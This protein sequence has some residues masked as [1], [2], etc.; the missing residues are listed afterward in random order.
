M[1][2]LKDSGL[3]PC[4]QKWTRLLCGQ[5]PAPTVPWETVSASFRTSFTLIIKATLLGSGE[6]HGKQHWQH[7]ASAKSQSDGPIKILS[8]NCQTA[9]ALASGLWAPFCSPAL[10]LGHTL[11]LL[12][13]SWRT[14]FT[15]TVL[16]GLLCNC[17]WRYF[18]P[19]SLNKGP[20]DTFL[21]ESGSRKCLVSAD[22]YVL[23]VVNTHK[24]CNSVFSFFH[25]SN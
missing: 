14:R 10:C 13:P 25:F 18:S 12:A 24:L 7:L 21:L 6:H 20:R 17:G 23:L 4:P 5:T 16:L 15:C 9:Q 11:G 8:C 2:S 1:E 19:D 3:L 22:V